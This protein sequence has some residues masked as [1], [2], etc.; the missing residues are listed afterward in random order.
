MKTII[1]HLSLFLVLFLSLFILVSCG[2]TTTITQTEPP[3]TSTTNSTDKTTTKPTEVPTD[4]PTTVTINYGE[5]VPSKEAT[6]T[7]DGNIAYYYVSDTNKYYNSDFIEV[8]SVV[9]SKK[10]HTYKIQEVVEPTTSEDGSIT[11]ICEVCGDT[12]TKKILSLPSITLSDSSI[13]WNEIENAVGYTIY[14]DGKKK[15]VGNVTTYL[16]KDLGSFGDTIYV[17]AYPAMDNEDYYFTEEYKNEYTFKETGENTQAML[18]SDFS[19]SVQEYEVAASNSWS[20]Y[21]YGNWSNCP[22]YVIEDNNNM[23]AKVPATAWYPSSVKLQKDLSNVLCKAGTYR[24]TFSIKLSVNAETKYATDDKGNRYGHINVGLWTGLETYLTLDDSRNNLS[25]A[26][27]MG[28]TTFTYDYTLDKDYGNFIH[29]C[30]IYWPEATIAD[31]Y[32]LIDNIEFHKL[33]DGKAV[34]DNLD[35]IAGGDFEKWSL[36]GETKTDSWIAGGTINIESSAAGSKVIEEEDGNMAL[37]I[38][39]VS[40]ESVFNL[41]GNKTQLSVKGLYQISFKLK[42]GSQLTNPNFSFEMWA[43]DTS[44]VVYPL[45][46]KISVDISEANSLEYTTYK[47]I[48]YLDGLSNCDSINVCFR[49]NFDNEAGD[50]NKYIIIDNVDIFK[51]N[52][53]GID[54][55][56]ILMI[57]NSF[58]DDTI[59]YV[60]NIADSVKYDKDLNL[61]G[62]FIGGCTLDMHWTNFSNNYPIYDLRKWDSTN[63]KWVT[64]SNV[65]IEQALALHHDWDYISFQQSSLYS[66][67]ASSY[68][69]LKEL[70]DGVREIVKEDTKFVWL[71]TWAY[72]TAYGT[73]SDMAVYDNDQMTMYNAICTQVKNIVAENNEY[74]LVNFVPSGTS[75]QNLRTVFQ[76]IQINRDSKHLSFGL[77]RFASS[78][79]FAS[80]VLD[81]NIDD[82]TYAPSSL[83]SSDVEKVKSAVSSAISSPFTVTTIE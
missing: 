76:E 18:N 38:Y 35:T 37:Y 31:N 83:S 7:E 21:P 66:G 45:L 53:G 43:W 4:A 40:P 8:E 74:A 26:N 6:C 25:S 46:D 51:V 75:V 41:S 49:I 61:Y 68:S 19:Y 3:V 47:V 14:T 5:L 28:W 72:S 12:D 11:Y 55:M 71:M 59:Q 69:H 33:E 13:S 65:S 81:I 1:K 70:T 56:N 23:C 50:E 52:I 32:V 39:G 17:L 2:D 79:T 77:G 82:V 34:G 57:G 73:E 67:Q 44:G 63:Q 58:M 22:Y 20:L 30:I 54:E 16:L 9:I 78:L 29:L 10:A 15:D 24:L 80:V 48:F 27:S 42:K 36:T 62:L 64:V 60:Y